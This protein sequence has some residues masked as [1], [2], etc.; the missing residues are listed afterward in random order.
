MAVC[1]SNVMSTDLLSVLVPLLT[2]SECK[3]FHQGVLGT[4]KSPPRVSN[5]LVTS[6]QTYADLPEYWKLRVGRRL[7]CEIPEAITSKDWR[8]LYDD[9]GKP[10]REA[11]Q[12]TP[13]SQSSSDDEDT[14]KYPKENT[15]AV[16]VFS[17]Q[18]RLPLFQ[19]WI[20]QQSSLSAKLIIHTLLGCVEP[21]LEYIR[22]VQQYRPK[23]HPPTL[24]HWFDLID[25]KA[26]PDLFLYFLQQI[27]LHSET[28]SIPEILHAVVRGNLTEYVAYRT[29]TLVQRSVSKILSHILYLGTVDQ[30]EYERNQNPELCTQ[31]LSD[32]RQL[33]TLL[34]K[35]PKGVHNTYNSRRKPQHPEVEYPVL[36]QLVQQ[37]PNVEDLV[38][39]NV[40]STPL[41]DSDEDLPEDEDDCLYQSRA[42]L[43]C[44]VADGRLSV[45][46]LKSIF[47]YLQGDAVYF[48]VIF[49]LFYHH[50]GF[51]RDSLTLTRLAESPFL[52]DLLQKN[53][54][55]CTSESV[56]EYL[57]NTYSIATAT[58]LLSRYPEVLHDDAL[59][60]AL[61]A[62]WKL[63]VVL[64]I[65]Q[66]RVRD[67]QLNKTILSML[68]YRAQ[69]GTC[70]SKSKRKDYATLIKY[71]KQ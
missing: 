1:M 52:E 56:V 39:A 36:F 68:T 10:A 19:W 2:N 25:T 64:L 46:S 37:W 18:H 7:E 57:L 49:D 5:L 4:S 55:V 41:S 27:E 66:I 23:I 62:E 30:L 15:Q 22:L 43:Y 6:L 32:P 35:L 60:W 42:L 69:Y 44:C 8:Q 20:Q 24:I 3:I 26:R 63:D 14:D 51:Y 11:E 40:R 12:H 71:L 17:Q 45:N 53:I 54:V 34:K 65:L 61:V 33:V 28:V 21:S 59:L 47:N 48:R 13:P 16:A 70:H 38:A 29:S 67:I 31:L 9:L 50:P 58:V